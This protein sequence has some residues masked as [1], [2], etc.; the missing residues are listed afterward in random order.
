M[1]IKLKNIVF[2]SLFLISTYSIGNN[3]YFDSL[4][5]SIQNLS[6]SEKIKAIHAIPFDK[7]NSNTIAALALYKESLNH[8]EKLKDNELIAVSN[9]LMGLAYYYK[10]DYDQSVDAHLQS[11]SYYE[12]SGNEDKVGSVYASLGYQM[13]RRN[14]SK[15]FAY[16]QKGV[17]VLQKINNKAALSA[18][19]NNYGVLHEMKDDI[20]SALFFY[21]EGLDIVLSLNDSIGIPY[22][23][24]NI[25]GAYVIL[26]DFKKAKPFY[27]QAFHIRKKRGDLNGLAE[28]YT[29]YGDFYFKQNQFQKAIINYEK[30]VD[31][32]EQINYT[33]LQKVDYEQLALCYSHLANFKQALHYQKKAVELKDLL[34]NE[35]TNKTINNLE[36]QFE[37]QKKEKLIAEQEL[38]IAKKELQLKQ[39]IYFIYSVL[40]IAVIVLIIGFFIFKQVRFKQKQLEEENRLKDQIAKVKHKGKLAEERVRIS[41]DLHDNIGSQ[42]T[43]IIS[44]IDN[45]SYSIKETNEELKSRL[46]ELNEFSRS[47]IAQLRESIKELNNTN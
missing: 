6:P 41:R 20:D 42:L 34:L 43:F 7:M 29:Y 19:Y 39:R 33:Y 15:A 12:K 9:E 22:S 27:D 4:T 23:L 11:I 45:M 3:N 18:A 16:M 40:G 5:T 2:S 32:C 35:S 31:F 38:V 25:A 10:G 46:K 8:S 36:I 26:G 21:K 13:K 14:L 28:N 1:L 30:A 24:N 37:T 47:A 17:S 44:S